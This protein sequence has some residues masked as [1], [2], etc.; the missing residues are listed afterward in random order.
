MR[1]LLFL[2]A[3]LMVWMT[4]T[5][6]AD[7]PFKVMTYNIRYENSSDGPDVWDNRKDVVLKTI[8]EADLVGLQEVVASQYDYVSSNSPGWR[9]YGV[10]RTDGQRG[11]EMAAIGWRKDRFLMVE[12]GTFWLGEDPY[13]VG[14]PAWDA[15]LPR[16]ASWV[17]LVDRNSIKEGKSTRTLL[18]VNAHFDHRGQQARKNSGM[19]IRKW[20]NSNRGSSQ[21]IFIGDLNARVG[22]A[23]L[24]ELLNGAE[25]SQ[26]LLDSRDLSANKDSGPDSTWN[27]FSKI[28]LGNRI[29][30]VL[31]QGGEIRVT[32]Y[33]TLDPRTESGRFASDHLPVLV[34][35]EW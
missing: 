13:L 17:R 6:R 27:G 34:E 19:Q 9:W 11:G 16:V 32:N 4:G 35:F 25:T 31:V 33:R 1:Q 14:K 15:A 23:P 7:E 21:A 20:I 24:Q 18:L 29:D 10:G 3:S 12:Q 22:S 8:T 26:A 2:A 28:E 30:H 5:V